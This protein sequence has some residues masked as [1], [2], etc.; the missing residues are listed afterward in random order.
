M[1]KDL[2]VPITNTAGDANA[3]A[4]AVALATQENAHLALLE[5][6]NLPMPPAGPWGGGDLG[7]GDLYNT[8]R[9]DAENDAIAWRE[10]LSREVVTLSSEVRVIES[11]FMESPD[12]A[13]LHARYTD[14]AVMTMATDLVR[15]APTI[16]DFFASLLL[17]SGRPLLLIPPGHAWRP[18]RHVVVA[19]QAKREAARALHDAMPFLHEAESIDVLEVGE[20]WGDGGDGPQPGADIAAHLARHGLK[21]RVVLRP[22]HADSVALSLVR[23]AQDTGAELIVAG[24]YGHSR[25]REWVLGG[26]TRELLSGTCSVPFLFSH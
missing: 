21:V 23:H 22:W 25:F 24:G 10:R 20:T 11:L 1:I 26:V 13:A 5:F 8:F 19:W 14:L 16:R 9:D 17:E 12:I 6:V 4:A 7:L 15:D 2:V 18:P 3:V